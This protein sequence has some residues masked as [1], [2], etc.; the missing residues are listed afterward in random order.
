MRISE[1]GPDASPDRQASPAET[2]TAV[3]TLLSGLHWLYDRVSGGGFGFD[4]PEATAASY[5]DKYA[6]ID[7]AVDALIKWQVVKAGAAGFVTNLGGIITLPLTIPV[8]L[9]AIA[10]IQLSTI[11]SIA[12]LRGFKPSDDQVRTL[13]LACLLGNGAIEL[14]TEFGLKVGTKMASQAV[15]SISGATLIRINQA[16]GFRLLTKTGTTGAVN[17]STIVPFI[18][19]AVGGGIDAVT[20]KAIGMAAK[21][22]FPQVDA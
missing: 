2:S 17:L 6:T 7:D 14:L 9:G 12:C 19:G 20:T 1:E 4:G 22:M 8:N 5:R 15:Q 10:Y 18:G 11:A 3:A 21:A 16:V 13:S